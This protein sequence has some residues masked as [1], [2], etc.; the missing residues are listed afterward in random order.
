MVDR[1][2]T[3]VEVGLE[4]NKLLLVLEFDGKLKLEHY[5]CEPPETYCFFPALISVGRPT[6]VWQNSA[7]EQHQCGLSLQC[8]EGSYL[9]PRFLH[10]LILRLASLALVHDSSQSDKPS[11]LPTRKSEIQWLDQ[12]GVET[13]VEVLEENKLVQLLMSC[14]EREELVGV[15]LHSL[16]I[17]NFLEATEEFCSEIFTNNLEPSNSSSYPL[18]ELC[19][20]LC[21]QPLLSSVISKW[22][23]GE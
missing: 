22:L 11:A 15:Q 3:I 6:D 2:Q 18:P 9:S 20:Q 12:D 13:I 7:P 10:V 4:K 21:Q 23:S 16:L 1:V 17:Q 14:P 8:F 19:Q 5:E